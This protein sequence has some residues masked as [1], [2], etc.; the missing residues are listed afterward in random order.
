MDML[1]QH[2]LDGF[3][4]MFLFGVQREVIQM[5]RKFTEDMCEFVIDL[6][7][8]EPAYT[9]SK[10]EAYIAQQAIDHEIVN[11]LI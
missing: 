7:Q 3:D 2:T 11:S 10:G 1:K 8:K 4:L 9:Y 6:I 5:N